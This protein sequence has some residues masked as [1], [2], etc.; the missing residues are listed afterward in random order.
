MPAASTTKRAPSRCLIHST[1]LTSTPI[2]ATSQRPGSSTRSRSRPCRR[3]TSRRPNAS[4]G[5]SSCASG[6]TPKPPPRLSSP[7]GAP[8]REASARSSSANSIARSSA[9]DSRICEPTCRCRPSSFRWGHRSRAVQAASASR[10]ETPNLASSPPVATCGCT[11]ATMPG[12]TRSA[13]RRGLPAAEAAR[14]SASSSA[15]WSAFTAWTPFRAAQAISSGVLPLPLSTRWL[16]PKPAAAAISSSPSEA[17]SAPKPSPASG[18]A[19]ARSGFALS[20]YAT[21]GRRGWKAERNRR[22]RASSASRS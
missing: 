8:R 6:S 2:G 15:T 9:E 4:S 10:A 21:S 5:N 20:A 1:S 16:G 12:L 18:A 3:S 7:S 13:T 19:S 11:G 14:S 22:A 17:A